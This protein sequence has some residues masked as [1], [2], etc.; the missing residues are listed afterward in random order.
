MLRRIPT[1]YEGPIGL[2]EP[3]SV[4]SQSS[5]ALEKDDIATPK[6]GR[7]GRMELHQIAGAKSRIHAGAVNV[8]THGHAATEKIAAEADQIEHHIER[9]LNAC[10]IL[11]DPG[12]RYD[13]INTEGGLTGHAARQD[14]S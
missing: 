7:H 11:N 4:K 6:I 10:P 14:L 8:H 3:D 9:R 13:S 2:Y 1:R 5:R 12:D